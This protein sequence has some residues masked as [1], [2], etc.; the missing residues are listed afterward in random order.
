MIS[1]GAGFFSQIRGD[2]P[3]A[4]QP[5]LIFINAPRANT[6]I[7]NRRLNNN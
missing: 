4:P 2:R 5:P 3:M 6:P 7:Q 1:P